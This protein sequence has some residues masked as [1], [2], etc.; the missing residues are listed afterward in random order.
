MTTWSPQSPLAK[1]VD[2]AGFDYDPTQ[3][4]IYS[5]MNALQRNFGYAYAF[6]A[7]ALAMSADLDCEP[8]FFEYNDKLWMIELWKGQYGLETGCEIGVY[9]RSATNPPAYYSLLDNLVGTRPIDP[10]AWHGEF[11]QAVDDAEMLE[12]TLTLTRDGQT[13]F[14]RPAQRHWWLTGFRWGVNSLPSDLVM[15][16]SIT[17]P[18]ADM[19]SAFVQAI[20]GMGYT[21]TQ[22]GLAVAFDFTTPRAPQPPRDATA[23]A[24][25]R[26]ANAAIVSIYD[27]MKLPNNDPNQVVGEIVNE[28]VNEIAKRTPDYFGTIIANALGQ[29]IQS[30]TNL[31]IT[32]LEFE[33]DAVAAWITDAGYTLA[34]WIGSVYSFV[35]DTFT[36][37]FASA[38]EIIN[39]TANGKSAALLTLSGSYVGQ[40]SWLIEPPAVIYPD[41][42]RRCYL[43][44]N[45]GIEGSEGWVE[46]SF[47]D[48][49]NT[50]QTVRFTFGC[51]TGFS[52]NYANVQPSSLYA[53]YAR[54]GS[55]TTWHN[56][57][58]GGGHPLNVA[59]AWAGGPA[60]S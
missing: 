47:V 52:D 48:E 10:V 49:S 28:I 20:V 32:D 57:V 54:S 60:P 55:D 31:F 40:G 42:T 30:V 25:V 36:M 58:P 7:D 27:A 33:A 46:Y 21:P 18:T 9:N 15:S 56:S 17:F 44:D 16:L 59:Y 8:I 51:P 29:D 19:C 41:Q 14:T 22:S 2:L 12:M 5:R 4:I 43:K 23:L 45:L 26:T 13:L 38:V 35:H 37:N 34:N 6:D 3:D 53:V 1:V 11:F 39:Q 24:A 50:N